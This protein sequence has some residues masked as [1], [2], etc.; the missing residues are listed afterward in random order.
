MEKFINKYGNKIS[1]RLFT[2]NDQYDFMQFSGDSNPIHIDPIAARRTIAGECIAHGINGLMWAFDEFIKFD[3]SP[4]KSFEAVFHKPITLDNLIYLFWDEKKSKLVIADKEKVFTTIL[5]KFGYVIN[6]QNN[7]VIETGDALP[8]PK[9][10]TIEECVDIKKYNLLYRGNISVGKILFPAFFKRYGDS[11]AAEIA[12]TS[13]IVG[14]QIPGLNSLFSS[15][16]VELDSSNKRNSFYIVESYDPRFRVLHIKMHGQS[17]RCQIEALY[18]PTSPAMPQISTLKNFVKP[19]EFRST[20]ALII[21]GSRGLGE[22]TAKLIVAGG[23]KVTITF[24]KGEGDAKKLQ[25]EIQRNGSCCKIQKLAIEKSFA[26]PFGN[27]NQLYYFPA[28]KIKFE[29]SRALNI[30]LLNQYRLFF[31]TGFNSL[32]MQLLKKDNKIKIFYPSTSFIDNPPK[33]FA[34]YTNTKLEGELLCRQLNETRD[35]KII[36]SRLP[37]MATDQTIGITGEQFQDSVQ[38]MLPLIRLMTNG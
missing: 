13:E 21:G 11:V 10:P 34:L 37:R 27:F 7:P 33:N 6:S 23:G 16:K 24:N 30:R 8:F 32:V 4:I 17:I 9:N 31:L 26:L 29:N 14:M 35:T 5:I 1:S 25:L 28:P 15:I 36:Y 19:N 3:S 38:V 20:N 12:S 18:R 22:L 2:I